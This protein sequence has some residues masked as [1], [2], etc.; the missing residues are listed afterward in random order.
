M[1]GFLPTWVARRRL[2]Y[3]RAGT[4]RSRKEERCGMGR[5]QWRS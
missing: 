3:V 2:H 5:G 1:V 4:F